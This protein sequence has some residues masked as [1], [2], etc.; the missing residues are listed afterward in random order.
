MS[1]RTVVL[2]RVVVALVGLLLLAAG[3]L[4]VDWRT[5]T[6][7]DLRDRLDAGPVL[8]VVDAGW[9][10]WVCAV[11]GVVLALLALAWL[12]AHLPH[13]GPGRTRLA[14]SDQGGTLEVELRSVASAVA[15]RLADLG[16]VTG[17]RGTTDRVR[18]TTVLEVRGR[19]EP[20]AD[21]DALDRAVRTCAAEVEQA[22]AGAVP[23]RVLLDAPRRTRPRDDRVRVQ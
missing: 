14:G 19:V 7:L 16:P 22:F 1:R 21:T 13:R 2:D 5:G 18:G 11:V 3:L 20:D 15:D 8:D 4:A 10:P 9:W 17:A 12:L 23:L 6:V